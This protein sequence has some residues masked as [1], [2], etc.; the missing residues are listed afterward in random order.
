MEPD[1]KAKKGKGMMLNGNKKEV[2]LPDGYF[3]TPLEEALCWTMLPGGLCVC[4]FAFLEARSL[5]SRRQQ[6]HAISESPKEY[7]SLIF[8]H[9]WCSLVFSPI[10]SHGLL[11]CVHLCL[12]FPLFIRTLVIGLGPHSPSILSS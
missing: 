10:G 8:Q 12:H 6:G 1:Y 11:L 3:E 5:K 9:H 4:C 7:S 2:T